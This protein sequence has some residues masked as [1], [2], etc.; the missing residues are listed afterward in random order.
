LVP[1]RQQQNEQQQSQ[2]P[3]FGEML[4][5]FDSIFA[6]VQGVDAGLLPTEDQIS[7]LAITI[8]KT[9]KL[10]LGS[11]WST[12]QLKCHLLFDGHLVDQVRSMFWGLDDKI[13]GMIENSHQAFQRKK[14]RTWNIKN[15]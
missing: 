2:W 11:G 4:G 8:E 6:Q 9:C 13:N 10:W 14:K 15:L 12:E 5:M 1:S 7:M 3:S